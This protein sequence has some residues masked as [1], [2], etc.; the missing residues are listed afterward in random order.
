MGESRR[1]KRTKKEKK[2]KAHSRKKAARK[3]KNAAALT[4]EQLEKGRRQVRSNSQKPGSKK[5]RLY[6]ITRRAKKV[7]ST[8]RQP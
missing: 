7:G 2:I 6:R 4:E 3:G 1:R 8:E 5:S